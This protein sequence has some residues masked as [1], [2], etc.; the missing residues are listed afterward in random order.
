MVPGSWRRAASRVQLRQRPASRPEGRVQAGPQAPGGTGSGHRGHEP[1]PAAAGEDPGAVGPGLR[2]RQLPPRSRAEPH[3]VQLPQLS[4][5]TSAPDIPAPLRGRLARGQSPCPP[6]QPRQ[7]EGI[8]TQS[9]D[10]KPGAP[11]RPPIPLSHR[12]HTCPDK[13]LLGSGLLQMDLLAAANSPTEPGTGPAPQTG[14]EMFN[15]LKQ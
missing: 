1:V 11:P 8:G 15:S 13:A 9:W 10:P 4:Q 14:H 12:K 5:G 2:W 7:R 6:E 3:P